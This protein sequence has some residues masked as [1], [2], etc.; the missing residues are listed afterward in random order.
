MSSIYKRLIGELGLDWPTLADVA[1]TGKDPCVDS[2]FRI[3]ECAAAV[4]GAQAAAVAEIW[5]RRSGQRQKITVD[6]MDGA[7]ATFSVHYQSQHGYP[8]PYPE[9]SYPLTDF[10]QTSDG[11]WFFSHGSFPLLRNGLLDVFKCTMDPDSIRKAVARRTAKHWERK[12]AKHGLCGVTARSRQ[13]W[14]RHKQ[15]RKLAAM[16][17]VEIT[18]IGESAP[19]PFG[20][21]ERPLD[22]IRA[23]D[24][25]HVIAGPTCGKTLA[26]QGAIVMHVTWPGHPGLPP[27][28]VDTTHGKMAALCD[29]TNPDDADRMRGLIRDADV[30][31]QS[32]HP[33]GLEALGFG[34]DKVAALRPGIVYVSLD[35]YGWDGPWKDRRGWEQLAQVATGMAVAQGTADQPALQPTY[36]NDYVTG[37]LAALGT[38]AA[39]IRRADEGGSYLVRVSLCRT[40]MWIQEQGTVPRL[41][42]PATIPQAAIDARLLTKPSPFGLLTYLGPVVDYELTPARWDRMTEPLGAS[43][44][45]WPQSR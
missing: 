26:E 15:G 20:P 24:L 11:K 31:T 19:E 35:C 28:D 8:I 9:P 10:H 18:K 42:P 40:A 44:A 43:P 37:F 25:T 45:R 2:P 32:Y 30:F 7:M 3:G 16:P 22:G 38:L 21:A 23:L 5:R 13:E 6:A 12:V 4:L 29:L 27:F 33:G 14:L 39:L 17:V 1:I 34:P 36:P 41:T